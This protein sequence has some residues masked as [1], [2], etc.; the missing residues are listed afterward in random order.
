M[1]TYGVILVGC[2]YMGA[3]HMDNIHKHGRV[4]IIGVADLVQDKAMEFAA[5][6]GAEAW[7]TDYR[8]LLKRSDVDIVIIAT[9]PSTHLEIARS[10]IEAGKHI[11]CEKP[12]AGNIN[13]AEEFIKL[14]GTANT[15]VMVGHILRHNNTYKYVA[16]MIKSGAI[17]SPIVMRMSQVKRTH[18]WESHLALLKDAS[19]I[20]DCGVHYVDVMRW[21]TGADVTSIS[22]IGQRLEQDVPE[23]TY[24]YGMITLK[25]TDGSVGY[26]EAGWGHAMPNDNLKE[27]IG[28]KGRIRIIYRD[29][30]PPQEQH[31][32][33]LIQLEHYPSGA[34]EEIN[35][36][37]SLKPTGVQF[38]YFL[39][40]IEGNQAATPTLEEVYRAMQVTIMADRAIME[41]R[42]LMCI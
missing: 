20:V 35:M 29:Q 36:E 12:I 6:Y 25:F 34:R 14:A 2:G 31:K 41:G 3:V 42:T 8:N 7:D 11:L 16:D 21:V 33:N 15:K 1:K 30:R 39:S 32:G 17:G 18:N 10:C 38:D 23:N 37:Y 24:N 9:Y 26:Y 5:K 13:E 27:F 40:M 22:G 28:P 19:P 4:R